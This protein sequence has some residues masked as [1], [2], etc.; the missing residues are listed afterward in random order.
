[1]FGGRGKQVTSEMILIFVLLFCGVTL[2]EKRLY[3]TY[4][5]K[6]IANDELRTHEKDYNPFYCTAK[7]EDCNPH[8][9]RR[10]D[11]T[12]NNLKYVTRGAAHT[13]WYRVL[14]ADYGK[15]FEPRKA[16][17]G[18]DLPL[19]RKV[20][21]TLLS[22]GKVP[23]TKFTQLVTHYWVFMAS[24]IVAPNDTVNYMQDTPYCCLPR[25]KT[26]STCTPNKVPNDDPVH[27]FDDIRCLNMTRP[28]SF[29]TYGCVSKDTTPER[30]NTATPVIDLSNIY[31]SYETISLNARLNKG[32]LL[33]YDEESGRIWP[34]SV[35]N[36]VCKLNKG[37]KE[38]RC[39]GTPN[40]STNSLL[41]IN[42]MTI[43]FWRQHNKIARELAEINP[44]WDDDK[45]F[46][47]ARDINIAIG[48]QIFMYELLPLVMGE[49]NLVKDHVIT[50]TQG[51]RDLY[52]PAIPPQISLEYPYALRWV[53]SIQESTMKMF[54]AEGYYVK[55]FPY[56]NLTFRTGYLAV[57][58]NLDYLTQGAF[59]QSCAKFDYIV[60]PDMTTI[61]L[62]PNQRSTDILTNDLAKARS[63]GFPPYIKYREFCSRMPHK[64]W[65]DL[66]YL[67]D[68]ERIQRL[69]DIYQDVE[70]IDLIAGIWTER[71]IEG[72]F[73]PPT[74]YCI[75]V[76]Q[77]RRNMAVDR[78]F[79]ER[80]NRP[81]AFNHEQ[82][83][84]IRK[85]SISR[86]MCDNGDTVT[87][88]Q[89]EG[90]LKAGPGNEPRECR[91][92]PKVDLRAWK[93]YKCGGY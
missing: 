76:D 60:D 71:L 69:Q 75:I 11:G 40:E 28:L 50:P 19:A 35:Q 14:P 67:I 77:L 10:L 87:H 54:D 2:G 41:G 44:C 48:T 93:D 89:P 70:D 9:G 81:N 58:N 12:C 55:E 5:D 86:F 59:R 49:D 90:F 22:E 52:N 51:F 38:T 43:W 4:T 64:S 3:D 82:L 21:T 53:H 30:I 16:K 47:T 79:Y 1:M 7:V 42:L 62:G 13:P 57:D 88:I 91:D 20:R 25:G 27:R 92:I 17:S 73:V 26:D 84:E 83:R 37:P 34:P 32:G 85:A 56:V 39:H 61:G 78:H 72:G 15:D 66:K 23:D 24:D 36:D 6:V 45:L 65:N 33:R 46:Y 18:A 68:E 74:F 31:G 29:Q 63:F 8:E 80:P